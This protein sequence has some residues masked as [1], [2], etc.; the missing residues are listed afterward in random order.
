MAKKSANLTMQSIKFLTGLLPTVVNDN[1]TQRMNLR[2]RFELVDS[3]I[4]KESDKTAASVKGRIVNELGDKSKISNVEVA[5]CKIKKDT[6]QAYLTGIFLTGTPIFASV[7]DHD[8]EDA[9]AMLTALTM[10]DQERFKWVANLLECI[11]DSLRRP[12]CAAEVVWKQKRGVAAAEGMS[13][14][15]TTKFGVA[16]PVIYEGNSITRIDPYNI[17][18]DPSVSPD[19]VHTDGTYV[20]YWEH[21]N[22]IQLKMRYLEWDSLFTIKANIESIFKSAGCQQYYKPNYHR[23]KTD[24]SRSAGWDTF[25]G[26]NATL[27]RKADVSGSYEVTTLYARLVPRDFGVVA[28]NDGQPQVFKL[29]YVNELLAYVEMLTQGHEFLPIIIG[30]LTPGS[31]D[32]KSYV[33]YLTDLQDLGTS[34][35]AGALNSMR[36][37]VSDRALYD[38]SRISKAAVESDSPVAKIPVKVN[39]YQQGLEGAYKQIPYED[40]LS[41]N[42]AQFMGM[43]DIMADKTVGQNPAS[44]GSFQKGNKT[45]TEFQTT[46][47]NSDA[48]MQLGAM[49]L[50]GSFFTPIKTVLNFNY[51]MN[52]TSETVQHKAEQRHVQID[53]T[54]LRARAPDFQMA[55]GIMPAAKLASTEVM[56]QAIT[57]MKQDPML[58][59]DYD[60]GAMLVS[61][62]KQQGFTGLESYKRSDEQK[63]QYIQQMQAMQPQGPAEAVPENSP[64]DK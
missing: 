19:K 22:Y 10:R 24:R 9:A 58:S 64:Q 33:E 13:A 52:A 49:Y 15:G 53:P 38:P 32:N 59:M 12:F 6:A 25:W 11:D 57:Y 35:L 63:Q 27:T 56:V 14:N 41:A 42:L 48:R 29:I 40:R 8:L 16:N 62:M 23:N 28:E 4:E 55:S 21:V 46:M 60:T 36:R 3:Y 20:G 45:T 1:K 7:T 34:L 30:Q 51:L 26:N 37:A 47:T 5:T 31:I 50:D 61:V 43:V 39:A 2:Y 44:Q 18:M 17:I 54:V